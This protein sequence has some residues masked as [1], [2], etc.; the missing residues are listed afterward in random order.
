M[1][2]TPHKL[3]RLGNKYLR[4][5]Q[6]VLRDQR[7]EPWPLARISEAALAYLYGSLTG[8]AVKVNEGLH[9]VLMDRERAKFRAYLERSGE[10]GNAAEGA[11]RE[12]LEAEGVEK[13]VHHLARLAVPYHV[14]AALE[15]HG[16]PARVNESGI[17][18]VGEPPQAREIEA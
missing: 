1:G 8:E 15:A 3:T 11:F 10:V 6:S 18:E 12:F 13:M 5:L 16:V 4:K 7:G 9:L 2:R 14:A 17:L